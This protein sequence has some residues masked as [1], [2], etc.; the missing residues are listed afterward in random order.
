M[1]VVV[2]AFF[3]LCGFIYPPFTPA[4]ATS[5]GSNQ[6]T[7]L[8]GAMGEGSYSIAMTNFQYIKQQDEVTSLRMLTALGPLKEAVTIE[9]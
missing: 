1:F 9:V 7:V 5:S 8:D 2:P 6:T 4:V 3:Y